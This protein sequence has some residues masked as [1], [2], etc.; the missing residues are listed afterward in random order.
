MGGSVNQTWVDV[1][2]NPTQARVGEPQP[3]GAAL[4]TLLDVSLHSGD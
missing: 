2:V 3:R 4:F 1:S